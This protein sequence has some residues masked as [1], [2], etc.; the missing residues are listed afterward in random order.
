MLCI[1]VW[2]Q[3]IWG[4]ILKP[5]EQNVLY[6]LMERTLHDFHHWTLNIPP[7]LPWGAL[8]CGKESHWSQISS[9]CDALSLSHT[10]IYRHVI[11]VSYCLFSEQN[12]SPICFN[13][14][15]D[16]RFPTGRDNLWALKGNE[17]TGDGLPP[18]KWMGMF[19]PGSL[20]S[21][22]YQPAVMAI[23]I[24]AVRAKG[25]AALTSWIALHIRYSQLL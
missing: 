17:V 3:Q 2:R 6:L 4:Y 7:R 9:D 10:P 1:Y 5:I 12:Q 21:P 15:D 16:W 19:S 18:E 20:C 8:L 25:G 13:E 11:V 24:G 22:G 23:L 14:R